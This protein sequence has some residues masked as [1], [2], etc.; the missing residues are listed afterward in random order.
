MNAPNA[1]DV[2]SSIAESDPSSLQFWQTSVAWHC[3]RE[4]PRT[5]RPAWNRT[6]RLNVWF[7]PQVRIIANDGLVLR[8]D[9]AFADAEV[10]EWLS[11][12][13]VR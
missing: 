4:L 9:V 13:G 11:E 2:L 7:Q 12:K 5:A 6:C 8:A 10:G 3:I 1:S